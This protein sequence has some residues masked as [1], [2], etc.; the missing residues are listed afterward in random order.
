MPRVPTLYKALVLA[1]VFIATALWPAAANAQSFPPAWTSTASYSAGDIVQYGG[2]WYRAMRAL[3]PAGPYPANAYGFWELNYVRSNTTLTIGNRQGFAN[4][5]Y[6]WQFARNARIADAAYL[7]LSIVTTQGNFNESFDTA[8]SLDHSFGALISLIGDDEDNITLNFPSSNG[9]NLDSGHNF[10]SISGMRLVGSLDSPAH[11]GI[12]VV[13]GASIENIATVG[14]SG[15]QG[16]VYAFQDASVYL[17]DSVTIQHCTSGI[18]ADYDASVVG[19]G[20][21]ITCDDTGATGLYADHNGTIAD[22]NATI[23]NQGTVSPYSGFGV[24]ATDGGVID[25]KGVTCDGWSQGFVAIFGGRILANTANLNNNASDLSAG[26]SGT[27][28]APGA[29]TPDGNLVGSNDGSYIWR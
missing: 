17:A 24:E 19:G 22:E 4:L 18:T 26:K 23:S 21:N 10:A 8:F 13:Y 20:V 11:Q 15:F 1:I 3:S 27:I 12:T 6:A 28:N 25:V 5:V 29:T 2:N 7:H 9:F 16:G 14:I